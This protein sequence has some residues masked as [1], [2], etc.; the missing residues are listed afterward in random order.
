M[1]SKEDLLKELKKEFEKAKEE[2]GF[3]PTF[4]EL[5]REFF[6]QDNVMSS[7]FI[8]S[9]YSRQLCGRIVDAFNTWFNY[10]HDILMPNP[11]NMFMSTEAKIFNTKEDKEKIWSLIKKGRELTSLNV[12]VGLK[13]DKESEKK[14]I[15]ESYIFWVNKFQPTLTE[16]MERVNSAW[17]KE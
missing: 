3:D 14:F 1:I 17:R 13:R 2:I 12:L 16:I 10:F 8:S 6:L 4:E 7:R 9:E 5:D 15:D 11:G